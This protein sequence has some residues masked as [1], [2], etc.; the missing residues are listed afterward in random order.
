MISKTFCI[1]PWIHL[2]INPDGNVLPCCIGN[3]RMP[4]GNVQ[5]STLAEIW[6]NDKFKSMRLNMLHGTQCKECTACY[7]NESAGGKSFRQHS[8]EEYAEFMPVVETTNNDGSIETMDLKFLDIRWSNICNFRC[9]GCSGTYSSSWAKEEERDD[10]LLISGGNNNDDLYQQIKP[11]LSGVREIYF[12]GGEPLLMDK[13][14]EIL[15]YLIDTNNTDIKLRYNTNLSSLRFKTI[16]VTELWQQFSNIQLSVSLDHVGYRAEYIREGTD[17]SLLEHNIKVVRNSCPKI[18]IGIASVVSVFNVYTLPDFIDYLFE[19]D[20][21][22]S[23]SYMSLYPIINPAFY[24]FK[25]LPDKYK[26]EVIQ[27]LSD[28]S[29]N[30]QIDSEIKTVIKHL[31]TA[32][33]DSKLRQEFKNKTDYFDTKRNRCLV[34]T[35]PELAEIY[36]D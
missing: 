34:E 10:I 13:H 19:N 12:A 36:F 14:Y 5:Q 26:N 27:K 22:D 1:L 17:W 30:K 2:N 3:H 20:I 31:E 29:Y 24:S 33:Y 25:I 11:Y 6:N 23:Y 21:I 32:Q 8:N 4:L 7:S 16:N 18:N 28:T 35:F 15:Q 9:K